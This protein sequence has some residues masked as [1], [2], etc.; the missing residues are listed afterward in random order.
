[1]FLIV[2][3]V[4]Y[5]DAKNLLKQRTSAMDPRSTL[6]WGNVQ[7]VEYNKVLQK[8]SYCDCYWVGG[9]VGK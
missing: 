1:V 8:S 9:N 4:G 3:Q 7:E 2:I 6:G 5:D